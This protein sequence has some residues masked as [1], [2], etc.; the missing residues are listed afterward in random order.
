[1][2]DLSYATTK[3]LRE[4]F[5][6]T[7][8]E[9][10]NEFSPYFYNDFGHIFNSPLSIDRYCLRCKHIFDV[11][12]A[13]GKRIIDLGCGVGVISI[14][15][16]SFGAKEVIAVDNVQ[17]TISV[18]EKILSR[19]DPPLTNIV[20]RVQDA[21]KLPYAD[22]SFDVVIARE[23][24]SHVRDFDAF[25]SEISRLLKEG[26]ILYMA[27]GNNSL[28]ILGR[29]ARRKHWRS[30]EQGPV[31]LDGLREIDSPGPY[32][33]MRTG[34]IQGKYPSLEMNTVDLLV[35]E[36]AGMWGDQISN[37]VD[38]YLKDGRVKN[39]PALKCR[40]PITGEYNELEFNPFALKKRLQ[41]SGYS[42]TLMRPYYAPRFSLREKGMRLSKLVHYIGAYVIQIFHPISVFISPF[43]EI[44]ARKGRI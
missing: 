27:D 6:M 21:L 13:R 4:I 24:I 23:C 19:L 38:G 14:Y 15:L 28:N 16:A 1:M 35:R 32:F 44:V 8:Q 3:A 17:E 36:T 18:L 11:T 42:A 12:H 30:F 29:R 9:I 7:R 5:Q 41:K 40:N 20:A 43:F 37:A 34:M 33:E 31:P 22:S 25:L 39:K 10:E 2:E 26:G